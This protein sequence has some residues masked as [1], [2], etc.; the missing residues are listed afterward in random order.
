MQRIRQRLEAQIELVATKK[1]NK[2]DPGDL[3]FCGLL[4]IVQLV[5]W[6]VEGFVL[7]VAEFLADER[8]DNG[9]PLSFEEQAKRNLA[10][11]ANNLG[12]S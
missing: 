4:V 9:W 5:I 11:R 12:P 7:S 10:R 1:G 6:F 2:P 3:V 8:T